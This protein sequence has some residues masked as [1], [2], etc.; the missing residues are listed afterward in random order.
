[1]QFDDIFNASV[2][3]FWGVLLVPHA[4]KEKKYQ[5]LGYS[6]A[7]MLVAEILISME[8]A[9]REFPFNFLAGVGSFLFALFVGYVI[10][11]IENKKT[12]D[13]T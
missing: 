12:E 1:M 2:L 9:H 3:V 4:F 8:F 7:F 13:K 10:Y 11:L 5:L 6:G